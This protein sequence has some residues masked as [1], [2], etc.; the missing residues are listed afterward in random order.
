MGCGKT[1]VMDLFY[2]CVAPG[3]S[4]RRVHFHAF[5]LEVT[6]VGL[7]VPSL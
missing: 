3:M 5:M 1:M 6:R 7:N 2:D 4:K